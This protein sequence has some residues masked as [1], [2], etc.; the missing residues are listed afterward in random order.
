MTTPREQFE[1]WWHHYY[2]T[3]SVH[4]SAPPQP[5]RAGD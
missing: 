3:V 1:A 4:L 2:H 5:R